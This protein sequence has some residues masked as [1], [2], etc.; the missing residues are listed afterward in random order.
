MVELERLSEDENENG[1]VGL[2]NSDEANEEVNASTLRELMVQ[3]QK[4]LEELYEAL[5]GIL[6]QEVKLESER[7]KE[8][9][10]ALVEAIYSQ[11]VHPMHSKG[12]CHGYSFETLHLKSAL[13]SS[14]R[15]LCQCK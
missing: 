5:D 6:A 8:V 14:R 13:N 10:V 15:T 4:E 3:K 7:V 12:F 1:S 2:E 11:C 9:E